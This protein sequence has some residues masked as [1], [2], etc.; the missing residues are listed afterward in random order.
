MKLS[1]EFDVNKLSDREL[2][3]L[4]KEVFTRLADE[5]MHVT[6]RIMESMDDTNA[7]LFQG[8][9]KMATQAIWG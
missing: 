5:P 2:A 7:D 9:V 6:Q 1:F 3:E 4:A 8:N